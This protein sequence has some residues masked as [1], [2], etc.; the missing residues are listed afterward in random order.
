MLKYKTMLDQGII[1]QEEFNQNKKE[2]L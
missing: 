2:L 1:N